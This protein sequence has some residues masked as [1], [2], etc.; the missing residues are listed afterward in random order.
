MRLEDLL[1]LS[2]A[3]L[4]AAL[5]G[6]HPIAPDALADTEFR[7]TSLGLPALFDRLFWKSFQKV[8]HS[9]PDTGALRGWNIR[10]EQRG[11]SAE[12]VPLRRRSGAPVTFGH[13]EVVPLRAAAPPP[14]PTGPGLL[15]DYGRGG[16]RRLDPAGLLR[17]P[18]VA[19]HRGSV[20]LLL[21][22]TYVELG[23]LRLSTPSYFALVPERPLTHI[24]RPPRPR[25]RRAT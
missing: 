20:E 10:V 24:A 14:R 1:S 3:E 19:L 25:P 18:L 12:S 6:G 5:A 21:G 23:P 11:V 13:F 7:G 9:D 17:D 4:G 16:N 2:P 15:L 22:W 8:F